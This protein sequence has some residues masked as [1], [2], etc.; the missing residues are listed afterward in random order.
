MTIQNIAVLQARCS[1]SRLPGK[2]LL[3]ILEKPMILHQID[4]IAKSKQIDYLIV[5]TSNDESDDALEE[6][7]IEN[8]LNVFRGNL[9]DVLDRVYMAV[10]DME[11]DNIVRLTGDCPL[12]DPQV[13]DRVIEDHINMNVDYTSNSI[14]P[15]FPDG[16]DVEVMKKTALIEAWSKSSKTS[17]RE[18]VTPYIYNNKDKFKVNSFEN[19]I[20]YSNLRWTVDEPADF[21]LVTK[22][23][24]ELYQD[25]TLFLMEDVLELFRKDKHLSQINSNFSRNE[26][27]EKSLLIDK[28]KEKK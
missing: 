10:R 8:N 28:K 21:E 13:I 11:C 16:L 4:R 5:A 27:L 9:D 24:E 1:S 17:E 7:C 6:L 23:Y 18:H 2:V 20:D 22:I 19:D 3:P 12:I 26:G 15:T 14:S 25:H